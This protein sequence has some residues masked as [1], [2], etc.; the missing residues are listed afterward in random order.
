LD[1]PLEVSISWIYLL[2]PYNWFCRFCTSHHLISL[3][4]SGVY[5]HNT[6]FNA[7]FWFR[8]ID[9]RVLVP[10]CHLAFIT[11]LVGEFL[12]PLDPHVQILKLGACRFFRWM[13]RDV[14]R[15]CGLSADRPY[16]F[17]FRPPA[18]L[19]NFSFQ[20]VSFFYTVHYCIS[21]YILAFAPIG[22]VIFL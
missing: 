15:K 20:L 11:P 8:F 18:R 16:P 7:Y 13:I 14:Q 17:P 4:C 12:T 3:L 9:T 1:Y 21:L 2:S 19:S 6:V 5:A 10:A 22:D